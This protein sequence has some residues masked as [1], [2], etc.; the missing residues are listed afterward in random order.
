MFIG[1]YDWKSR[2]RAGFSAGLIQGLLPHFPEM[3]LA[4]LASVGGLLL[5]CVALGYV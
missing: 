2:D 5:G 4:L 3:L 1:L